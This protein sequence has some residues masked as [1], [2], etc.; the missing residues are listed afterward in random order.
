VT[1][2]AT[3]N[4]SA[5]AGPRGG[6][7]QV[8]GELIA[9]R[10]V[11]AYQHLTFVAPGVA[12]LARPGQFVALA[13]GGD[14][15]A[16]LLRRCLS[17]DAEVRPSANECVRQLESV[18]RE[19]PSDNA[20]SAAPTAKLSPPAGLVPPPAPQALRG[21]WRRAAEPTASADEL[22]RQG[23]RK[24][25]LTAAAAVLIA[26]TIAV[27][28]LLPDWVAGRR[29]E[30]SPPPKSSVPQTSATASP[31]PTAGPALTE[32]LDFE[33]LAALKQQAEYLRPQLLSRRR[34]RSAFAKRRDASGHQNLKTNRP[35][36]TACLHA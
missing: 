6:V 15:S 35:A 36:R 2:R 24:G 5:P 21:D 16:N 1:E 14:T 7:V 10:R 26:L 25:L 34:F 22:R 12:E 8:T 11:G 9:T 20:S 13:V 32:K 28:F 30:S 33:K 23:F 18:L 19:V 3:V 31:T 27:F 29:P 17:Q 4:G